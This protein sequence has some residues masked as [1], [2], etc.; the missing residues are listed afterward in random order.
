MKSIETLTKAKIAKVL[1]E[2]AGMTAR[3]AKQ[4][5]DAFFNEIITALSRGENVHL[6]GFGNFILRDKKAR[7]GRNPKTGRPATIK[8]RRVVLFHVGKIFK[9]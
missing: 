7:P 1:I 8:A 5:V 4:L 3:E 9:Q 6:S 2:K